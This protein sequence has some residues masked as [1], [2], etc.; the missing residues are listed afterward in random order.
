MAKRKD[1]NQVAHER[2]ILSSESRWLQKALFALA[3]AEDEHE[4]LA[5]VG[6][7]E[8][9][10]IVVS[11]EGDAHDLGVVTGALREAV[12]DRVEAL[13]TTMRQEQALI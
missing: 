3:K 2:R 13:R 1:R 8:A 7:D 5:S 12:L 11:I 9:D 4:K 10:S 6:S